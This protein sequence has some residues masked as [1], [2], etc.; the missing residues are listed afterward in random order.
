MK[1]FSRRKGQ[2][3]VSAA[4]YRRGE[5]LYDRYYGRTYDFTRKTGI[6][7]KRVLLPSNAPDRFYDSEILWNEVESSEK[8]H[9]SRLAREVEISLP[10]SLRFADQVRMVIRYVKRCYISRGMCADISIHDKGDR[11]PHAHIMLTT[12]EMTENGFGK[13]NREWDKRNNVELWRK[14]WENEIN[15]EFERQGLTTR[16]NHLSYERQ[17]IDR[18]PT[19]H[20]GAYVN[21]LK[22]RG[23]ETNLS[24]ENDYIYKENEKREQKK[25]LEH[26]R[27]REC[28]YDY[29]LS[30]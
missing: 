12:R 18:T 8:R 4:A 7:F 10:R 25:Q 28:S 5:R 27:N 13:K 1:Y 24:K 9:D 20:L 15:H 17:G 6:V 2:S 21:K 14:E 29:E 3:A 30:F 26:K 16:V 22:K 23:I 11:N 19:K